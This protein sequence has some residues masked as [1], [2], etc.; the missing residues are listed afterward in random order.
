MAK[1][2]QD[3]LLVLLMWVDNDRKEKGPIYETTTQVDLFCFKREA[4]SGKHTTWDT[5]LAIWALDNDGRKKN[6]VLFEGLATHLNPV[7][8]EKKKEFA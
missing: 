2:S 1:L 8:L 4:K 3:L 7:C 6:E 5:F